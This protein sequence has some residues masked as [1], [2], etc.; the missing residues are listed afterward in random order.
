MFP[1]FKKEVLMFSLSDETIN[2]SCVIQYMSSKDSLATKAFF[3]KKKVNM[4]LS[5]GV[6]KTKK[7]CQW[8]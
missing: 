6:C 1:N 5:L 2:G 4:N 8:M 3:K 7:R